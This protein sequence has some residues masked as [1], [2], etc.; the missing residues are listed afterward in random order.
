M[1]QYTI[2]EVFYSL[3]GE[4]VRAGTPNIFVRFSGCNLACNGDEVEPGVFQPVCDTEFTSGRKVNPPM[5]LD[6]IER[7]GKDCKSIIFTGGEPGLQLDFELVKFLKDHSYFL[8]I[9]TNGTQDLDV[10]HHLLDWITCSPK[11]AEHTLKLPSCHELKYVRGYG[12]GIPKPKIEAQHHLISPHAEAG[13]IRPDVLKWCI[14]L[15]KQNPQWR[16]SC[17]LHKLW[18]VR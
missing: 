12:Q 3:Q 2:N 4:G 1:K 9:E 6:W 17:Q 5:L 16:L 13:V 14:D 8:A 7:E 15:V 10:V 18:S 11:T